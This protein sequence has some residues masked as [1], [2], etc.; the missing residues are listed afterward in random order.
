VAK[1]SGKTA[2]F[3]AVLK[4]TGNITQAAKSAG[5]NKSGHYAR[6]KQDPEY[7][8]RVEQ[9]CSS[10]D[11]VATEKAVKR[12]V[13]LKR[14]KIRLRDQV[15]LLLTRVENLEKA[16]RDGQRRKPTQR[17]AEPVPVEVDPLLDQIARGMSK[18]PFAKLSPIHQ[19]AVRSIAER[20]RAGGAS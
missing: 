13:R 5:C 9:I 12:V 20:I 16:L 11:K 14:Q 17:T 4:L 6:M 8:A 3:L 18:K 1:Y 15:A 10:V 19:D 7:K 2:A